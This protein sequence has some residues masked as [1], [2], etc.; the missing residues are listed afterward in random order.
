MNDKKMMKMVAITVLIPEVEESVARDL[1]EKFG[2]LV[3]GLGHQAVIRGELMS[4]ELPAGP[5]NDPN[6]KGCRS[7]EKGAPANATLN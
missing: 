3:T 6:C 5:C 4:A 1:S 7:L 2:K